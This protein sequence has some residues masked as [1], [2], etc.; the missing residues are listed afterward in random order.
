VAIALEDDRVFEAGRSVRIH[1]SGAEQKIE[2]EFLRRQHGRAVLKLKDVDSI[3]AAERIVGAELLIAEDEL[4][5]PSPGSFYTFQL[6][7]CR[8]FAAN[9]EYLGSVTDVIDSGGT[10]ILQVNGDTEELLIPFA[11][12]YLKKIDIGGR[13]IDVDL[14]EGLRGINR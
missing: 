5:A 1:R 2:I 6:K 3:A 13:R 12:S 4:P 8:V 10:E 14:P 9:E 7:G 11:Q